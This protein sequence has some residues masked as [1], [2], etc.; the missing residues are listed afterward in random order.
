MLKTKDYSIFKFAR[1]NREVKTKNLEKIKDSIK[2]LNLLHLRPILVNKDMEIIDGQHRFEAAKAMGLDLYYLIDENSSNDNMFLLNQQR[3]WRAEDYINFYAKSGNKNYILIQK[4]MKA[5]HLN[6]ECAF[7]LL[8]DK[9]KKTG[10]LEFINMRDGKMIIKEENY[11]KGQEFIEYYKQITHL[12]DQKTQYRKQHTKTS[13]FI[14]SLSFFV[15]YCD[16]SK[17]YLLTKLDRHVGKYHPCYTFNEYLIMWKNI[18][19]FHNPNRVSI[20]IDED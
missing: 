8:M 20:G 14:T 17:D 18:Y 3:S 15:N 11:D 19:N 2:K 4:F 5:N 10:G 1:E 16:V 13:K 9:P 6:F 12:I 7:C